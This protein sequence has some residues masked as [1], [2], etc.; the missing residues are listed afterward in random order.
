MNWLT[1][2]KKLLKRNGK[3]K[4]RT[5]QTPGEPPLMFRMIERFREQIEKMNHINWKKDEKI[6]NRL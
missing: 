1:K 4:I 5:I 3:K 2:V 6:T